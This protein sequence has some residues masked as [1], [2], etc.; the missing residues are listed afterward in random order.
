[1]EKL[2][3]RKEAAAILGI[4]VTTLDVARTEGRIAFIQHVENGRVFFTEENLLEYLA[5]STHRAKPKVNRAEQTYRNQRKTS[6]N[7][8]P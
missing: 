4:S 1:M 2:I 3:T 7:R 8:H 6:W 5:R